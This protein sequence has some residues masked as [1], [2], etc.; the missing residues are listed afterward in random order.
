MN[1]VGSGWGINDIKSVKEL[2]G[3]GFRIKFR[4]KNRIKRTPPFSKRELL[5]FL[6]TE[7]YCGKL[8]PDGSIVSDNGRFK[9]VYQMENH[10]VEITKFLE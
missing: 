10:E 6:T 8:L 2:E 7:E 9:G 5:L 3:I 4:P 1:L